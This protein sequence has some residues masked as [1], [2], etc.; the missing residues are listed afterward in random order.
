MMA[1]PRTIARPESTLMPSDRSPIRPSVVTLILGAL[2]AHARGDEPA[3]DPASQVREVLADKCLACHAPD[4]KKANLDLSRRAPTLL[5]GTGG[6]AVVPGKPD[7]SLLIEKLEAGEMPPGR[8]LK[9]EEI[10]AFR[11][12]IEAGAAYEVEPVLAHRAGPDWWSLRPI[13]Q[14]PIPPVPD[15]SW[16]RTPVDAF[17]LDQ[18]RRDGLGHAPEVD[19]P[20]Y[21]RRVTFDL[22]GLPP[23]PEEVDAYLADESPDAYERLVDRLLASPDYGVRWA[24]LW[25]D[26]ARFGESNGFEYDEFRPGA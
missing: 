4:S 19:R 5:G 16:V 22:T 8:A 25:L 6:P 13:K 11:G 1:P 7:E 15:A 2:I 23:T 26:L 24:R 10:A 12:W 3:H 14:A 20:G 9:P 17:V 18:L 21:I